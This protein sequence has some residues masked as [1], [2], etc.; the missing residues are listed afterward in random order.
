MEDVKTITIH[1]YVY[2]T[3][4]ILAKTV[5]V[6]DVML[7]L[8]HTMVLVKMDKLTTCV[9]VTLVIWDVIVNTLTAL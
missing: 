2:V 1:T 4:D 5:N 3:Q 9:S 6:I 7:R 8:V